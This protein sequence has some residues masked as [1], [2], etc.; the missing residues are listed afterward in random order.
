MNFFS[1]YFNNFL[2]LLNEL[3]FPS[4]QEES[5]NFLKLES[6]GNIPA[7]GFPP[8]KIPQG[9]LWGGGGGAQRGAP[10]SNT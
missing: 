3:V 5:G 4:Y 10:G 1:F 8:R 9:P 6:K 7:P 2:L